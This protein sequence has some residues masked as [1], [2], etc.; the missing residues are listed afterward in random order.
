M[1]NFMSV[2]SRFGY[3]AG[4]NVLKEYTKVLKEDERFIMGCRVNADNVII[5]AKYL[6]DAA[7]DFRQHLSTG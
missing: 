7:T 3:A 4:D 2:N 1:K 6:T 5:L